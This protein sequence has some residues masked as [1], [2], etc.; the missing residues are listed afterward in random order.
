MME[1][2]W[3]RPTDGPFAPR[4]EL[5]SLP[6]QTPWTGRRKATHRWCEPCQGMHRTHRA[7][8]GP[9]LC[10]HDPPPATGLTGAAPAVLVKTPPT[11]TRIPFTLSGVGGA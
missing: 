10:P 1:L 8:G 4:G 7:V 2:P 5:A 9:D 6:R 11:R 3:H